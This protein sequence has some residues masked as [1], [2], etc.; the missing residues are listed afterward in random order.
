MASLDQMYVNIM[1]DM[2][3]LI[4]FRDVIAMGRSSWALS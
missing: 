1:G 4:A 3:K 2:R